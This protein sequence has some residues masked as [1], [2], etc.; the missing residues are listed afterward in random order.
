MSNGMNHDT[1]TI[2]VNA[3]E[4]PIDTDPNTILIFLPFKFLRSVGTWL[5]FQR[6]DPFNNPILFFVW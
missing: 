6:I 3:I 1:A 2:F 4:Y 5:N